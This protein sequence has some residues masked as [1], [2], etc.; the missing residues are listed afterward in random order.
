M[1]LVLNREKYTFLWTSLGAPEIRETTSDLKNLIKQSKIINFNTHKS[2]LKKYLLVI[3]KLKIDHFFFCYFVCIITTTV[4]C[5]R[6]KC[7]QNL[8]MTLIS[9]ICLKV[10]LSDLHIGYHKCLYN[11]LNKTRWWCAYAQQTLLNFIIVLPCN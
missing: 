7:G 4:C 1:L 6:K 9:N 8:I 10:F 3:Q 11:K 2:N 5:L